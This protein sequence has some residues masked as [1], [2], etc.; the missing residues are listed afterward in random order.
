MDAVLERLGPKDWNAPVTARRRS[1]HSNSMHLCACCQLTGYAYAC[2][3]L[4]PQSLLELHWHVR[5]EALRAFQAKPALKAGAIVA[6]R[7]KMAEILSAAIAAVGACA[8]HTFRAVRAARRA[9]LSPL[10]HMARA[11]A[12]RSVRHPLGIRCCLRGKAC[13]TLRPLLQQK[14]SALT[15]R[16][17][18][19]APLRP[20][21]GATTQLRPRPEIFTLLLLLLLRPPPPFAGHKSKHTSACNLLRPHLQILGAI[22]K[23]RDFDAFWP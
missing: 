19:F 20:A 18:R 7:T 6:R 2:F 8:A 22:S 16:Q 23:D 9:R 13:L 11:S 4:L 5:L 10:A 17:P 21:R 14:C 3:L 12:A 15:W 1:H